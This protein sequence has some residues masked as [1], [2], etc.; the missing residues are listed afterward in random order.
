[1]AALSSI[2]HYRFTFTLQPSSLDRTRVSLCFSVPTGSF[3]S[4][5]GNVMIGKACRSLTT[6]YETSMRAKS[7]P[8]HC[9]GPP[10]KGKN[11]HPIPVRLLF[12]HLSGQN[13]YASCP[14]MLFI[15]EFTYC[16]MTTSS[17]FLTRMGLLPSGPP[18]VGSMVVLV[19]VRLFNG[20]G[21]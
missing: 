1:M 11:A 12:S 17:P 10:L 3:F 8:R 6:V 4:P 15:R 9:R 2:C 21:G 5:G 18:P 7:W 20:T 16:E 14:K 13:S 19:A